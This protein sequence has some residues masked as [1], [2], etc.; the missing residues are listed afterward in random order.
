MKSPV[1][2]FQPGGTPKGNVYI[3]WAT[4]MASVGLV[5]GPKWI[6]I[7]GTF[8]QTTVPAGTWNVDDV[9]L[10]IHGIADGYDFGG[11][12]GTLYFVDGAHLAFQNLVIEQ[13][14]CVLL[15]STPVATAAQGAVLTLDLGASIFAGVAAP[16]PFLEIATNALP[17]VGI[18]MRGGSSVGG[19]VASTPIFQVDTGVSNAF[20]YLSDSSYVAPSALSGAGTL[21]VY[22]SPDAAVYPPQSISTL[23]Q[24]NQGDVVRE[25]YTPATIANWSGT[26]PSSAA[27]ALDRIAA[28][29]GPIP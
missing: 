17:G 27:N 25:N 16:A 13:L 10:T 20:L 4:M 14:W 29:V 22:L 18:F 15:G 26:A 1:F 2:V 7:D 9:T 5:A 23:V 19:G 11:N 12:T 28:K 6:Q 24:S 3:D 21:V 8:A